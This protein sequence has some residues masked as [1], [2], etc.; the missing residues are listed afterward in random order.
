MGY[1]LIKMRDMYKRKCPIERS[2]ILQ[3]LVH[4]KLWL[5]GLN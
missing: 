2:T 4:V 1:K 3:Q 5:V